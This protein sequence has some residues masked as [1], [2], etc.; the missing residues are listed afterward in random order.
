MDAV[1]LRYWGA[2]FLLSNVGLNFITTGLGGNYVASFPALWLAPVVLAFGALQYNPARLLYATAL[3]TGGVVA[4]VAVDFGFDT[5]AE[6]PPVAI[7]RFFDAPPN[8]MRLAMLIAAGAILVAAAARTRSLLQHAIDE[9]RRGANLTRYLNAEV[10]RRI[11]PQ[12]RRARLNCIGS[13]DHRRQRRIS[14]LKL[15][16]RILCLIDGLGR[17]DGDRLADKADPIRGHGVIAS[18]DRPGASNPR[19]HIGRTHERAV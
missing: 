12:A 16:G 14:D 7:G 18:R 4:I 9:A 5:L 6:T 3:L 15:L 11:F 8:I 2:G 17:E 10:I 13:P 1:G 19:S